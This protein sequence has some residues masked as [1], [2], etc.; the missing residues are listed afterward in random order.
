MSLDWK[1][2]FAALGVALILE[3]IPYFIWAEKMP[4]YLRFLS[5]QPS[6]ALRRLG[7]VSMLTG[8][9]VVMLSRQF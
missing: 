4:K 8:L 1:L 5:K 3:G 9:L 6:S 7:F 2:L